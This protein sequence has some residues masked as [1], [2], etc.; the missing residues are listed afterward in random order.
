MHVRDQAVDL[1]F[2]TECAA[3]A[4]R[5]VRRTVIA[6]LESQDA[7]IAC[8]CLYQFDRS[9]NGIAPCRPAKLDARI[10]GERFG[11]TRENL[12]HKLLLQ[13]S[14]QVQGVQGTLMLQHLPDRI[15]D[16]WMIVT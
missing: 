9:F 11:Q 15:H 7:S 2:L 1:L 14:R 10:F 8:R 4:H 12:V 5:R 16:H 13:G 3:Q 6:T